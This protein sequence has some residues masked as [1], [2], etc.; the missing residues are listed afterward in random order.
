MMAVASSLLSLPTSASLCSCT[1][2]MLPSKL[3]SCVLHMMQDYQEPSI[4]TQ[5]AE[6]HQ[7]PCI[8]KIHLPQSAQCL[9]HTEWA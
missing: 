7:G 3:V 2:T 9:T 8:V 4:R 5:L 1:T 6:R